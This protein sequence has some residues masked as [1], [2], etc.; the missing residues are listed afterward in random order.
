MT[1]RYEGSDFLVLVDALRTVSGACE[2]YSR[3]NATDPFDHRC[4]LDA[5][6]DGDHD[7]WCAVCPPEIRFVPQTT[8]GGD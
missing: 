2:F 3:Q 7:L 5:G 6:H 8:I 1:E 4:V